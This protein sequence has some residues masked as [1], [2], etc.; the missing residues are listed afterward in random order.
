MDV[1]AILDRV[2]SHALASGLFDRCNTHEPKQAPGKGLSAA[3]WAQEIRPLPSRSGLAATSTR[4]VMNIRLYSS[5][6]QEPQDAIDPNLTAACDTLMAAYSGDFELGGEVAEVDLL[7]AYGE[8]LSAR[9]GYLEQDHRMFR[10]YT[11]TMPVVINDNYEQ[12][13]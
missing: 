5:M 1:L 3:I 4:L 7:G 13:P 12:S 2:Q 10:V 11:I 8:P 6:V 9:A